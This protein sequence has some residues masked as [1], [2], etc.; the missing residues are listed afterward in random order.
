MKISTQE[1]EKQRKSISADIAHPVRGRHGR[2]QRILPPSA[3]QVLMALSLIALLSS[4]ALAAG[5]HHKIVPSTAVVANAGSTKTVS[6]NSAGN[7]TAAPISPPAVNPGILPNV[8]S[9]G[10]GTQ[11]ISSNITNAAIPLLNITNISVPGATNVSQQISVNITNAVVPLQ[12]NTNISVSGAANSTNP[13]LPA[14]TGASLSILTN[15][16]A[17]DFFLDGSIVGTSDNSGMLMLSN[18]SAGEHLYSISKADYIP[19]QGNFSASDGQNLSLSITLLANI[20]ITPGPVANDT[21]NSTSGNSTAIII[22]HSTSLVP[23][24]ANSSGSPVYSM[25]ETEIAKFNVAL[26]VP[27]AITWRVDGAVMNSTTGT[28]SDFIWSPGILFTDSGA[29]A[30]VTVQAGNDAF[31]WD[32]SVSDVINPFFSSVD[33]GPDV[34]GSPDTTIHVFTKNNAVDFDNLT[35]SLSSDSGIADY[36]LSPFRGPNDVEWKANIA[37]MPYGNSYLVT[38]TG[39]KNNVATEYVMN[40]E[41]AH[42]RTPPQSIRPRSRHGGGGGGGGGPSI[43]VPVLVNAIFSKGLLLA[44]ETQTLSVDAKNFNGGVEGAEAILAA[45]SGNQNK[46]TLN[47][48]QGTKEYGT[49]TADF[50]PTEKGLFDLVSVEL[51]TASDPTAVRVND[52]SFYVQSNAAGPGNGNLSLIYSLLD[53]TRVDNGTRIT[54]SID[55]ADSVGITSASFKV[56]S[57]RKDAMVLPM[58]LAKGDPQYGT[59]TGSFVA[60]VPDTTYSITEITL[61]GT[62]GSKTYTVEGRSVYVNFVPPPMPPIPTASAIVTGGI[63]LTD[64]I[65]KPIAPTAIGFGIMSVMGSMALLFF[66]KKEDGKLQSVSECIGDACKTK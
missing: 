43:G 48:T 4:T 2:H 10:N 16:P 23:A 63:S 39:V 51:W 35:V 11:Q 21:G 19:Y 15:P 32:I 47:L 54:L 22:S 49:W 50:A 17:S 60:E 61:T 66:R 52:T 65:K 20:S 57:T 26:K 13:P 56:V 29:N 45:P 27:A 8:T 34:I 1:M 28:T 14:V 41:R 55:A 40:G 44:N 25:L 7:A 33:G 38:I 53:R 9:P 18:I 5:S 3:L 46:L 58:S 64:F 30:A 31:S 42:Y 24:K 6:S 62:A 59:W 12:N 37:D 36:A